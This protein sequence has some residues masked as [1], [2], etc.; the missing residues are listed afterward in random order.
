[1]AA[2][3]DLTII[4]GMGGKE[5]AHNIIALDPKA[6]LIVSSGYSEDPVMANP[7]QYGFCERI[8]KPYRKEELGEVLSR[9]VKPEK[10]RCAKT[11]RRA[12]GKR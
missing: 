11:E 3:F 8:S 6:R 9:I 5:A 2:I 10:G 7:K 4:D 12:A 1:M